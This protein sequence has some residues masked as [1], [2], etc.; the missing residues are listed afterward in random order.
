VA[1][2]RTFRLP[3][4]GLKCEVCAT[5]LPNVYRTKPN[6]GFIMRE[7]RCPKCGHKNQ[8]F[9]RVINTLRRRVCF[10]E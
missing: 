7:R 2:Q 10:E 3:G 4:A 1:E 8:T 9:E 5:D 6:E